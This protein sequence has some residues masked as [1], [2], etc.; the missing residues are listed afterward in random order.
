MKTDAGS[1]QKSTEMVYKTFKN[2]ASV[3]LGTIGSYNQYGWGDRLKDESYSGRL[4]SSLNSYTAIRITYKDKYTKQDE[5]RI[6]AFRGI[7]K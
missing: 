5:E 4:N 7:A 1:G 2:G 3:K 6:W